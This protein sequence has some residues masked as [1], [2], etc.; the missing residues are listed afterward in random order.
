MVITVAKV[1]L[2]ADGGAMNTVTTLFVVIVSLLALITFIIILSG[3][4]RPRICRKRGTCTV[5]VIIPTRNEPPHVLRRLSNFIKNTTNKLRN[6][7]FIIVDDSDRPNHDILG[8]KKT[9]KVI[10]RDKPRGFKPGAL[11]DALKVSNGEIVV[12][13]DSDT[14]F[15]AEFLENVC[16]CIESGY[17][18]AQSKT[19]PESVEGLVAA[20]YASYVCFRND[21]LLKGTAALGLPF[22][23]GYG[24]GLS[25]KA[26]LAVGGW[27]E[28]TLAEDIDLFVTLVSKGERGVIIEE[29]VSELPPATFSDLRKQQQRW[30]VGS[31]QG[32]F[33]ALKPFTQGSAK[34]LVAAPFLSFYFGLLLN[35]LV[36]VVP[37]VSLA[38]GEAL[39]TSVFMVS[40]ALLNALLAIFGVQLFTSLSRK[41]GIKKAAM[42]LAV[43]SVL[44]NALSL[45]AV[46]ALIKVLL[47]GR[48]AWE[49]TGKA[50]RRS[51]KKSWKKADRIY[52]STTVYYLAS[53]LASIKATPLLAGWVGGL[54][55][56][57]IISWIMEKKL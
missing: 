7:E 32:F 50:R 3:F 34:A 28:K 15:S 41:I 21:F 39:S 43:G 49:V 20:A 36:G 5:S 38:T 29:N 42:G 54:L 14:G 46:Y 8:L 1:G 27:S 30:I 45:Y 9:A 56:S 55:L 2:R 35:A 18:L 11:N 31:F 44:Y 4:A 57:T 26:I 24:Y 52:F 53:F 19:F 47:G 17:A 23:A 37:I 48:F 10:H 6:V 12:I 25:R 33:K 51:G 13:V 16:G 22:I 40:T